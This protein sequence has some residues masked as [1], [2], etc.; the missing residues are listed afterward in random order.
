MVVVEV[1]VDVEVDVEV[2]VVVEVVVDVDVDVVVEVE[3][4]VVTSVGLQQVSIHGTLSIQGRLHPVQ[5]SDPE[6][7]E[8]VSVQKHKQSNSA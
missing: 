2:L 7:H 6:G 4:V 8:P 5:G 3:V 1:E